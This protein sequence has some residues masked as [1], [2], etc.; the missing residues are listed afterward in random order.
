MAW[1]NHKKAYD[2]VQQSW[3]IDYLKMYKIYNKVIKFIKET[4]KNWR[5]ELTVGGKSLAKVKIQRGIFQGDVLL[6]LLLVITMVPLNHILRKCPNFIN[7][8]KSLTI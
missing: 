5:V 3:I 1:I 8:E 7:C 4:M 2:M 6:L